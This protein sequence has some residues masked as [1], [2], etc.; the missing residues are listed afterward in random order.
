MIKTKPMT[1]RLCLSLPQRT[2]VFKFWIAKKSNL[3]FCC[4]WNSFSY[5][6]VIILHLWSA[7]T[8][9]K[10]FRSR[11]KIKFAF[12]LSFEFVPL[13]LII[14]YFVVVDFEP[15]N[16]SKQFSHQDKPRAT[17]DIS[18]RSNKSLNQN[19]INCGHGITCVGKCR[20]GRD[21]GLSNEEVTCF[22]DGYCT[23]FRDCCA[24]YE[25]YCL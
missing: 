18:F 24:D 16:T 1:R 6:S 25:Q 22:C 13:S 5:L 7:H 23:V 3:G 10:K 19:R 11:G 8:S 9:S 15:Q 21:P 2:H 20:K 14:L 12:P 17:R 4:L